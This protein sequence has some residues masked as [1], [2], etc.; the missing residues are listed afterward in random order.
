MSKKLTSLIYILTFGFMTQIG[1][2]ST[3]GPLETACYNAQTTE[4]SYI[5]AHKNRQGYN[6]KKATENMH[7]DLQ[8]CLN[9]PKT[10]AEIEENR[11]ADNERRAQAE[12]AAREA[13]E[14]QAAAAREEAERKAAGTRE[15]ID[16]C[17]AACKQVRDGKQVIP[18]E[19]KRAACVSNCK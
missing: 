16:N 3:S 12:A 6:A 8:K 9:S 13:A 2:A 7:N 19:K 17:I 10:K 15:R 11:K 1:F 5:E 18:D 4:K 14:R